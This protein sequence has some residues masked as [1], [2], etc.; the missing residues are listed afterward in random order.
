MYLFQN[1]P[2]LDPKSCQ[3][4]FLTVL[5]SAA[6]LL[7][8]KH[9]NRQHSRYPR[10]D[11]ISAGSRFKRVYVCLMKMLHFATESGMGFFSISFTLSIFLFLFQTHFFSSFSFFSLSLNF[12]PFF[13]FSLTL[14]LFFPLLF[15][16]LLFHYTFKFLFIFFSLSSSFSHFHLSL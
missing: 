2:I 9:K 7:G 11:R 5:W 3:L 4:E 8:P 15:F 6:V 14:F 12:S 16:L 1:I 13:V 10:R